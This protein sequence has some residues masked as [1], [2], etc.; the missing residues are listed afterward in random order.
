MCRWLADSGAPVLLEDVPY[1]PRNS[2]VVQSLVAAPR[3]STGGD[4]FRSS[5][6]EDLRLLRGEL[7]FG[8][9]SLRFQLTE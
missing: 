6:R 5:S 8:Q 3:C 9:N 1:K 4:G 2:L 7:L